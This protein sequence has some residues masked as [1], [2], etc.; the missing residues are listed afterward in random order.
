MRRPIMTMIWRSLSSFSRT[1]LDS[2]TGKLDCSA[3]TYS[4]GPSRLPRSNAGS[5]SGVG[6]AD[7]KLSDTPRGAPAV[8]ATSVGFAAA[9]SA[10]AVACPDAGPALSGSSHDSAAEAATLTRYGRS[11]PTVNVSLY[12]S[13]TRTPLAL[14]WRSH[15]PPTRRSVSH[16]L[17]R[18]SASASR[19]LPASVTLN[20]AR[21]SRSKQ[22]SGGRPPWSGKI[23]PSNAGAPKLPRSCSSARNCA[24]SAAATLAS[25][26][27]TNSSAAAVFDTTRVKS[28]FST[29]FSSSK[30]GGWCGGVTTAGMM[31]PTWLSMYE[32]TRVCTR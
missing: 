32:S 4:S 28:Q 21:S 3:N 20:G 25:Y 14:A 26:P 31:A 24:A 5:S 7:R 16:V 9:C 2:A 1:T 19:S 17:Y 23:C 29:L 10:V 30:Y 15:A 27:N 12:S 13:S 8:L 6:K 22:Y 11:R 18:R